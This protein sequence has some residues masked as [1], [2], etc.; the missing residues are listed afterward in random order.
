M[1]P[2]F[3]VI[4]LIACVYWLVWVLPGPMSGGGGGRGRLVVNPPNTSTARPPRPGGT[5]CKPRL[6]CKPEGS[7]L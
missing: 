5:G 1:E 3:A 6:E 2:F 7:D 4:G